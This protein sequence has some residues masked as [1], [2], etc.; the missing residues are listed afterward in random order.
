[1]SPKQGKIF[2]ESSVII[3]LIGVCLCVC[4][5]VCVR[6]RAFV[7]VGVRMCVRTYVHARACISLTCAGALFKYIHDTKLTYGFGRF[8]DALFKLF[9]QAYSRA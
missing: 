4:V 3:S 6:T 2:P 7:Y 5:C 1:M 8:F 9:N